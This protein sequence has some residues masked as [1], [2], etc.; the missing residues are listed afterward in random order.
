MRISRNEL[1]AHNPRITDCYK[2][3]AGQVFFYITKIKGSA[4]S[5]YGMRPEVSFGVKVEAT[6]EQVR[7]GNWWGQ[8]PCLPDPNFRETDWFS[9]KNQGAPSAPKKQVSLSAFEQ[10]VLR[11]MAERGSK[12]AVAIEL[13]VTVPGVSFCLQKLKNK[14]GLASERE[15]LEWHAPQT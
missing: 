3:A 6:D 13:G 9:V 7:S 11:L 2:D 8:K 10:D 1:S 12:V 14:L 15:V 5:G 4:L